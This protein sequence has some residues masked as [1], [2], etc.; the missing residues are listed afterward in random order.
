MKALTDYMAEN[1]T[2]L[3]VVT[4]EDYDLK[5]FVETNYDFLSICESL[6]A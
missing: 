1:E 2:I 4:H 5:Y 6:R 3:I